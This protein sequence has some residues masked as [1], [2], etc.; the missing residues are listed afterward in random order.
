M[1]QNKQQKKNVTI[2]VAILLILIPIVFII[3]MLM[4]NDKSKQDQTDKTQ[5]QTQEQ[6]V[7]PEQNLTNALKVCKT[8]TSETALFNLGKAYIDNKMNKEG[9]EIYLRVIRINPKNSI[10]H[11]NL[12]FAYGCMSD[13]DNGIKYCQ[14]SLDLDPNFQLAKNNLN[15]M[16]EEKKKASK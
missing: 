3:I 13:W 16:K 1:E 2:A 11:N 14:I 4:G 15:W 7:S 5:Q 8:D 6:N 9:V 10:A 12:G